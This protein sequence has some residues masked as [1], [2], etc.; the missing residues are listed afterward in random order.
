[1]ERATRP[2]LSSQMPS[3]FRKAR[4]ICPKRARM[5][6]RCRATWRRNSASEKKEASEWWETPHTISAQP[7]SASLRKLSRSGFCP[8][9]N[10][11]RSMPETERE[12]RKRP[13]CRRTSRSIR[14]AAGRAKPSA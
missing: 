1:M 2:T 11:S 4:G 10:C 9:S 14:A 7:V 5:A 8:F 12:T 3:V 13:R 6:R